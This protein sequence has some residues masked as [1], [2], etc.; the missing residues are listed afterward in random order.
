MTGPR[1]AIG[2]LVQNVENVVR[3]KAA[4]CSEWNERALFDIEKMWAESERVFFAF[5]K[6]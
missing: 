2:Q 5:R 4:P 3:V 6:L 1:G